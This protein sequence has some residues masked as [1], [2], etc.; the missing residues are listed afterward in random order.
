MFGRIFLSFIGR[1]A[2]VKI[3]PKLLCSMVKVWF[4]ITESV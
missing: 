4:E 3:L 1:I 2:T